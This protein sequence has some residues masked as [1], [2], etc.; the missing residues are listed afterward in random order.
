MLLLGGDR[1]PIAGAEQQAFLSLVPSAKLHVFPGYG[2]GVNV[3][4]PEACA[5]VA[6]EFWDGMDR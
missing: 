1:S 6:A 2:H 5:K 4:V 3:V